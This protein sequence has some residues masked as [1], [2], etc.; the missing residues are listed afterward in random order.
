MASS[1]GDKHLYHNTPHCR[2]HSIFV[3][4]KI[5]VGFFMTFDSI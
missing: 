3:A 1:I 2:I 4:S 5:I